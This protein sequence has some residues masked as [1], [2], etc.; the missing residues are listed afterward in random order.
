MKAAFVNGPMHGR[1]ITLIGEL[2][3]SI[4]Y[5]VVE[6][7]SFLMHHCNE[8]PMSPKFDCIRYELWKKYR[9]ADSTKEADVV[10]YTPP[11]TDEI[12][13]GQLR[14]LKLLLESN[15]LFV[16]LNKWQDREAES[17]LMYDADFRQKLWAIG[18]TFDCAIADISGR[19]TSERLLKRFPEVYP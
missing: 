11:I 8:P 1:T 5:P 9:F 3:R 2:K 4:L 12:E 10:V 17:R 13:R 6:K 7:L 18:T 19:R 16:G 14:R 15:D